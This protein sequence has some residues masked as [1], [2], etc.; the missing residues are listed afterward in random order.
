MLTVGGTAVTG[1]D[2]QSQLGGDSKHQVTDRMITKGDKHREGCQPGAVWRRK[3]GRGG[4][5][6]CPARAMGSWRWP[7]RRGAESGWQS[8]DRGSDAERQFGSRNGEH[9]GCTMKLKRKQK[10]PGCCQG[11]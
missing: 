5:A 2:T 6:E 11:F 9:Y 3:A 1:T 10:E 7:Y 8:G 4:S